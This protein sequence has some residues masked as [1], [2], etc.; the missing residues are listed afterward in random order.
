MSSPASFWT[1]AAM[2][3]R[4]FSR[5]GWADSAP[6]GSTSCGAAVGLFYGRQVTVLSKSAFQSVAFR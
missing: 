2:R 1:C 4:S 3:A 5:T 6:A